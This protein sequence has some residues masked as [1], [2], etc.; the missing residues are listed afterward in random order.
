MNIFDKRNQEPSNKT[1]QPTIIV[2]VKRRELPDSAGRVIPEAEVS[3]ERVGIGSSLGAILSFGLFACLI[4]LVDLVLFGFYEAYDHLKMCDKQQL[5]EINNT[6][7]RQEASLTTLKG[8][9]ERME[10][11]FKNKMDSGDTANAAVVYQS[12]ENRLNEYNT[13]CAKYN[14][15]IELYNSLLKKPISRWYLVPIPI[16]ANR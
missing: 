16:R 2:D 13:E 3:D 14:K 7:G 6:I 9:I 5:T 15:N 4:L 1:D 8:S 11:Q 10:Q 12:Y